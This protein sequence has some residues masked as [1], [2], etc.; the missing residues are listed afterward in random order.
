M[1]SPRYPSAMMNSSI[2]KHEKIFMMCQRI[3]FPPISTIGFGRTMVSSARR[4][5]IPPAKIMAFM[6]V[7]ASVLWLVAAV[8]RGTRD[9][10]LQRRIERSTRAEAHNRK[11]HFY[12]VSPRHESIGL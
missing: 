10:P 4:D 8:E 11:H 2:P 9:G 5:P 3:G 7:G 12:R 6:I 1:S